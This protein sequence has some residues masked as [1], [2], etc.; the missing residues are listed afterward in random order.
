MWDTI[1][2][3]REIEAFLQQTSLWIGQLVLGEVGDPFL[4]LISR[5]IHRVIRLIPFQ[6]R[7]LAFILL[8]KSLKFLNLTGFA[9][10]MFRLTAVF[11][12]GNQRVILFPGLTALLDHY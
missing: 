3:Y 9:F 10:L 6:R 12:Y 1:T 5:K 11:H 2:T 7:G 8:R 4:K